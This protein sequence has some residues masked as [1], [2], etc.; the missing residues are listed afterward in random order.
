L[1]N[2]A[3][4]TPFQRLLSERLRFETTYGASRHFLPPSNLEIGEAH[5]TWLYPIGAIIFSEKLLF[6]ARFSAKAALEKSDQSETYRRKSMPK[7]TKE[8]DE[9][10]ESCRS[11]S[12]SATGDS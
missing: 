12:Q 3:S 6:I 7:L 1:R 5:I 4:D 9:V 8:Y 11:S 10:M 2:R